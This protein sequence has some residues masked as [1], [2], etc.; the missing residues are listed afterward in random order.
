[1]VRKKGGYHSQCPYFTGSLLVANVSI[2]CLGNCGIVYCWTDLLGKV[3]HL[4]Q[5]LPSFIVKTTKL[6]YHHLSKC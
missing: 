4:A 6:C 1:M 5:S 3:V 2:E